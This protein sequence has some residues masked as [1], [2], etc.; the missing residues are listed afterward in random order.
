MFDKREPMMP[1]EQQN[2]AQHRFTVTP[3]REDEGGYH[4]FCPTL[5]GC[6]AQTEQN[7]KNSDMAA[8]GFPLSRE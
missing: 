7:S 3:G 6:H 5:R 8:R 1:I 2:P 4:V